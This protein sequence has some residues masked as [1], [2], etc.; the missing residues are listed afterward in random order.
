M[1]FITLKL[2]SQYKIIIY[3][4]FIIASVSILSLFLY[5]K[6]ELTIAIPNSTLKTIDEY[7]RV[8]KEHDKSRYYILQNKLEEKGIK[9]NFKAQDSDDNAKPLA[10]F[11]IN[12]T[13]QID[14]TFSNNWG[15]KLTEDESKKALS[16]G[17]ISVSPFSFLIK[18]KINNINLIKDL[19]GK[20]IAFWSS[21]EGKKNPVFTIGGDKA[22][23]YSSDIFL[24]KLF[25]IAGVTAENSKLMNMWPNKS[26][27][28]DDWDILLT[29]TIPTKNGSL[30]IDADIYKALL[31][32]EIRFLEF[33][34]IE[35]A[36]KNLPHTK[37]LE[38]PN[39]LFDPENNFPSE[40]FKTLGITT[41]VFARRD[42]DPSLVLILSEV[43][44][45]MYG[46]AGRFSIKN[47]YPNFTAIE[48]FEPSNVAEKF[49]REGE[50]SIFRK[51]FPPIFSALITKLFF[52]LA[53]IFFILIPL[54]TFFP[55]ALKKYF[56]M[57]IN[58]Y[59]EEIYSIEK[60][61][62]NNDITQHKTIKTRLDLLDEKVRSIK[63]PLLQEEFVQQIFIVREH[64]VLIQRKLARKNNH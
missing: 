26:T 54:T 12:N 56:Q 57:R 25:K 19:K 47:E 58:K 18:A 49:Y 32:K 7:G 63:F 13:E 1:K 61:L 35:A 28:T 52:V 4:C 33:K 9:L 8:K 39:S 59:Y 60:I 29:S 46:K 42:L 45:E 10:E 22:A 51:Y 23:E 21:P 55:G 62:E 30:S 17:A 2:I 40:S 16:L 43:L 20:K 3:S 24:E 6:T 38:I 5:P 64:I 44:K 50:S 48:I 27:S 37:L 34:D 53:P 41:S 36:H 15:G 14:I 31:K 11:L